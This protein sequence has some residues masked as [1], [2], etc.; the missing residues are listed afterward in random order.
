MTEEIHFFTGKGGTGKSLLAAGLAL[1][2]AKKGRRTLLVELGERSFYKD[3]FGLPE[4]R[5]QPTKFQEN[6]DISL[7]SGT[8]CLHEYARSLIKVESLTRLFFENSVSQSLI[9]VA[10]GLTELAILGK[11]TSGPRH[12]GPS[13]P[14]EVIVIDAFAT[15]HFLALMR[16]PAGMAEAIRFGPMGEQSRGIDQALH[17]P[18]LSRVHVVC[19]PEEMPVK[20][21]EELV[22]ALREL[23]LEPDI[24]LNKMVPVPAE[25]PPSPHPFAHFLRESAARQTEMRSRLAKLDVPMAEVPLLLMEDPRDLQASVAEVL[26]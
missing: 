22:A 8:E 12:Y 19:L 10:P 9:N 3:F 7:W 1:R 23:K 2:E 6:L 24:V 26:P 16:A 15:G 5:Y 13:V 17:D 11:A 20:E 4:V 21:T 25:I 14:H 18:N